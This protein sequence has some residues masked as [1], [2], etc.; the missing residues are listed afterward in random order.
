MKALRKTTS[1]PQTAPFE[2]IVIV[3]RKTELEELVA[4]FNTLPQAQFY[5]ERAGQDF[6][7]IATRHQR[8]QTVLDAVRNE[9]PGGLNSQVIERSFLPQFTFGEADLIITI[10]PDGLVVN[11]AKYLDGQPILAVNP[12]PS[13]ID[14]VLL[15]FTVRDFACALHHTM[16]R[17]QPL[18]EVTMAEARLSDG[19]TL[20]AFNDLFIGARSHVSARYG[21][22]QRQHE[23]THSSSGIIVST[24]A[25]STGWL[26]SVYAGAAAVTASL[27]GQSAPPTD[28]ERMPL[29]A[30][31]LVYAVRE[32]FPSKAT[33]TSLAFGTIDAK[34]PLILS[35]HMADN[36]VIFS[37]G[38][39]ADYLAFNA[40]AR[41]RIG[42]APR[43]AYLISKR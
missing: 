22:A 1:N 38:M 16:N 29:D 6:T 34:T 19:Q 24:G 40:G 3:T 12:D 31:Y 43:N 35:S 18:Q 32:P 8:Y 28:P 15:P 26:R 25:G 36:G 33:Q 4:R 14:G 42:I 41:A 7:P 13:C 11:V 27:A 30:E 17:R 23:E 37:D 5:L 9:I 10:G 2:K 21:I 39:E 20:L